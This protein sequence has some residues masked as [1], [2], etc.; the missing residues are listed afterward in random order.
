M[1]DLPH[2][3]PWFET[4]VGALPLG[5]ATV[6]PDG[7]LRWTNRTWHMLTRL[8]AHRPASRVDDVLGVAGAQNRETFLRWIRDG[9]AGVLRS[10]PFTRAGSA[11]VTYADL[12]VRLV[13]P[14]APDSDR[15]I[16]IHDVT[17]RTID[18]DRA[19]LFYESF[20]TSTNAIEIT[21]DQGVIVD[22]NPA[23]ERI[24]GYSRAEC[25][26]QKP[27]L[28]RSSS[29]PAGVYTRLW[30]D[31]LDPSRGYWS[32]E[33]MNRDRWGHE[34]LVLLTISAVRDDRGI[35]THYLGVAVDL[36]E[37]RIW[38]RSAAHADRLASIGQ[39]AAGVA[40]EINT[41]LTN[42]MLVA[43]SVRRRT[44]DP[45]VLARVD[46]ITGQVDIAAKIVRGLLD[47]ARRSEPQIAAL[48]LVDVSRAAVDFLRGK[49]S[50]NIELEEVYPATPVPVA[51]DRGQ[52][53]QVLTNILNNG[54][55]AMDGAPGG[56]LRIEVRAVDRLAEVEV[57]DSGPGISPDA[58]DHLFEPFFTTKPEGRGTGL[59]LA[60]CDGLIQAHH[61]QLTARNRPEGGASFVVQLPL[62]P[63]LPS[64]A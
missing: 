36:T 46:A 31:L 21:D 1:P 6:G 59:G 60:I 42:V 24:Y 48:D 2:P 9:T 64:A 32:G 41:P 56:R 29:T 25:I 7:Q 12:E 11:E 4:L 13:P 16:I 35:T 53:I 55:E 27:S 18:H 52:L 62:A 61:G 54:Y 50:A 57:T 8:D 10:V 28:V 34:R 63:P 38:Q 43:E 40:H 3:G 15:L 51:G 39:L 26:G 20:L 5:L 22:V 49:Q 19:R 17:D 47:F 45:W 44:K 33:I 23:F 37:Q 30:A 58:I 14:I